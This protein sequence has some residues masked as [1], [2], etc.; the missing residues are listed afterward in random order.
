MK[1]RLLEKKHLQE[2]EL[3]HFLYDA[4]KNNNK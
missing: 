1:K 4:R 2:F 3:M